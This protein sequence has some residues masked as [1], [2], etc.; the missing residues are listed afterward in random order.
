M[1]AIFSIFAGVY[2]WF[3]KIT[4]LQY[5]EFLSQLH[6][7]VFFIGVNLTFFPMHFLG[8][9]GMP[10]RIPDY[11][12]AFYIFNKIASWGSYLSGLSVLIFILVL[13]DAFLFSAKKDSTY[14][15]ESKTH[16]I[17]SSICFVA[18][19]IFFVYQLYKLM[20]STIFFGIFLLIKELKPIKKFLSATKTDEITIKTHYY[21]DF[22]F[23]YFFIPF[24]QISCCVYV[25]YFLIRLLF[26]D[27]SFIANDDGIE[28]NIIKATNQ[29]EKLY[30][31]IFIFLTALIVE[32]CIEVYI[33]L[34]ANNPVILKATAV[35]RRVTKVAV[36]GVAYTG[37]V[38]SL[39]VYTPAVEVPLVNDFHT[40][41]PFGRGWGYKTPLD[42]VKGTIIQSYTDN[43]SL[44]KAAAKY[45]GSNKILDGGKISDMLANEPS[46]ANNIK[47]KATP[48]E[49]RALGFRI[50]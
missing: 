16:L 3:N 11:P 25:F 41:T 50:F 15:N 28:V 42:W 18:A 24:V 48:W 4:G 34:T 8:V 20:L 35:V 12:D 10:R 9:A 6:F 46:I 5:S 23:F 26:I 43:D 17:L 13:L 49:Q 31:A 33:I 2:Y 38:G 40:K 30:Y 32:F 37:A 44:K 27:V 19:A 47:K 14:K 1:G 36:K 21:K 45:G 7:W 22:K 39:V 29:I